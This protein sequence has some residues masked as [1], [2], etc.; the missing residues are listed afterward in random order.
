MWNLNLCKHVFH[1][2]YERYKRG[3]IVR[4]QFRSPT[5]LSVELDF[6]FKFEINFTLDFELAK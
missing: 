5:K 4:L 1:V 2:L 3:Q 6:V